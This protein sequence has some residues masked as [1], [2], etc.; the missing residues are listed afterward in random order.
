MLTF[1]LRR[2][3]S[4]PPLVL[5]VSFLTFLL[6]K[7]APGDFYSQMEADPTRSTTEV[8]RQKEN[9]GLLVRLVELSGW[10][11]SPSLPSVRISLS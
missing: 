4:I 7:Q 2:L 10:P 6:L 3:L 8:L 9:A 11:K 5:V 1:S